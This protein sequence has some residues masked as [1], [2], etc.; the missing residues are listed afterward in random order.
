MHDA[1]IASAREQDPFTPGNEFSERTRIF[2]IFSSGLGRA[3][4]S[5]D[6]SHPVAPKVERAKIVV[7]FMRRLS[8]KD[9]HER[10]DAR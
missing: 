9:P 8:K 10:M 5:D 2:H 4:D 6:V 1:H 7:A 3:H